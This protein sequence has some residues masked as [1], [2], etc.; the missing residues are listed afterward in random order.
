MIRVIIF[1][2][3]EMEAQVCVLLNHV[4]NVFLFH[5]DDDLGSC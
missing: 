3:E 1:L 2:I 4:L 5:G